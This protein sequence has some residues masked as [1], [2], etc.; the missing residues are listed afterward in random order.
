M[1]SSL[2]TL[3]AML[4]KRLRIRC[5]TRSIRSLDGIPLEAW[6]IPAD[7]NKLL[8]VNHPMTCNRYGFPGHLPPWNTMFGG[9]EVNFLPE[10]KHLHDAGYNILTYDLRNHGLSGEANGVISGLGLLECRDVAGSIRY[11]KSQK[12]LASMTTGLYSRCMGGNSTIIAMA[13]WPE[14][15]THI[16]ALVVLNVVS[17]KTFIERGAENLHLDPVKAV[18]RL[19]ERVRELT[20]FR[21]R[22]KLHCPMRNT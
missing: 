22:K 17:G 5:R 2:A 7:S 4:W 21:L 10:L 16:Q 11:A 8:I 15:F 13:K 6:F 3:S 12:N 14:E 19:D 9:F 20:G 1:T 18:A